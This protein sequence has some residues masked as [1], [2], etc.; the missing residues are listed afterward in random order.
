MFHTCIQTYNWYGNF[1]L[2]HIVHV[3]IQVRVITF[4]CL[5][6]L[7]NILQDKISVTC[8]NLQPLKM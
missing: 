6:V 4:S 1:R 7:T 8:S 5:N 3:G 2:E